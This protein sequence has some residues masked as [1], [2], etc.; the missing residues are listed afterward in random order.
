M[1]DHG[2]SINVYSKP[3]LGTIFRVYLSLYEG[4]LNE[5]ARKENDA[6]IESVSETIMFIDDD[7]AIAK[8]FKSYNLTKNYVPWH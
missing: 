2:G 1:K 8:M 7:A 3:E 5:V 6:P 4:D